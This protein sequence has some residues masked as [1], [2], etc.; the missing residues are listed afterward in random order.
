M[1]SVSAEGKQ[2]ASSPCLLRVRARWAYPVQQP[3]CPLPTTYRQ[4][5]TSLLPSLGRASVLLSF[6]TIVEPQLWQAVGQEGLSERSRAQMRLSDWSTEQLAYRLSSTMTS[7]VWLSASTAWSVHGLVHSGEQWT[8]FVQLVDNQ[9][10]VN[11][12]LEQRLSGTKSVVTGL[13]LSYYA[14]CLNAITTALS[15]HLLMLIPLPSFLSPP[16][17]PPPIMHN[18][19]ALLPLLAS[20]FPF[21]VIFSPL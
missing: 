15:I 5:L 3:C 11:A 1:L 21:S 8:L 9:C 13:P 18:L 17:P 20:I 6:C 2:Q 16:L 10:A 14:H 12:S 19:L 4:S 7:V